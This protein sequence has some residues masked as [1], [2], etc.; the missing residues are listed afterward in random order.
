M[1]KV[2]AVAPVINAQLENGDCFQLS[3]Y[4]GKKNVVIFFFPKAFTYG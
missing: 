1:L 3:D 4:Q 2:G